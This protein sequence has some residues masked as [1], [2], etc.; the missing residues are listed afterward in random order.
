MNNSILSVTFSFAIFLNATATFAGQWTEVPGGAA[1]HPSAL[2]GIAA[3]SANDI[4]AV[5]SWGQNGGRGLIEH[6]D[7]T[8]W[9][10]TAVLPQGTSLRGVAG[11]SSSDVWAVG[12]NVG[13]TFVEHWNG[14][15]W[16][17]VPSPNISTYYNE[18]DAVCI[19]SQNDAWGVGYSISLDVGDVYILMH[20]DGTS[21][22]V[23]KGP[24]ADGTAL[25]SLKAFASDDVWAVGSK[26]N[27]DQTKSTFTLHWDGT[28]WSEVP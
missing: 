5:G 10:V 1:P 11:R 7:G 22:S 4:W 24:P 23:V 13:H 26:L 15:R 12:V 18:L 28:A 19:I 16:I 9:S 14:R 17:V 3:V 25:S 21:W 27:S 20:W 2:N 6:W 8:N